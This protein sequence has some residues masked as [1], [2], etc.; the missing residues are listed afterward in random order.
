MNEYQKALFMSAVAVVEVPRWVQDRNAKM[1][2]LAILMIKLQEE[3][4]SNA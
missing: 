4:N 1:L 3:E 2:E